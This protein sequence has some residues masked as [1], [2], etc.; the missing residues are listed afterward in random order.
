V[1]T[2]W[3]AQN[4]TLVYGLTA[5]TPK[6][7][8]DVAL[9]R[10]GFAGCMVTGLDPRCACNSCRALFGLPGETGPN[11]TVAKDSEPVS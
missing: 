6:L 1:P 3:V 5:L 11:F 9:G 8:R 2:L 10:I 7:E 4:A